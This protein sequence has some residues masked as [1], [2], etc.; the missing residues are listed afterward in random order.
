MAHSGRGGGRGRYFPQSGGRRARGCIHYSPYLGQFAQPSRG[1]EI[2]PP[3]S[4]LRSTNPLP[5]FLL[6]VSPPPRPFFCP[7]TERGVAPDPFSNWT[8]DIFHRPNREGMRRGR[9]GVGRSFVRNFCVAESFLV[10]WK[11]LV[12]RIWNLLKLDR[13]DKRGCCLI[14]IRIC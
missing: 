2:P 10:F 7:P 13:A 1:L 6:L 14:S 8:L 12:S 3:P 4:F 11:G 9:V 5:P